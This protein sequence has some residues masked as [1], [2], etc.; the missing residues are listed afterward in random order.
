M[1]KQDKLQLPPVLKLKLPPGYY[2]ERNPRGYVLYGAQEA[3]VA[4]LPGTMHRYLQGYAKGEPDL[5]ARIVADAQRHAE[6]QAIKNQEVK[7]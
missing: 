7:S 4:G 2:V 6:G 3:L 5:R 1:R